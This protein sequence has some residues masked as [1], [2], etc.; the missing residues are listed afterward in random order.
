[1]DLPAITYTGRPT[2]SVFR[3]VDPPQTVVVDLGVLFPRQPFY[4]GRYNPDGLQM[5]ARAHGQLTCWG[6]CR[7]G[8]WW[9]LVTYPIEFGEKCRTVTHWIPAWILLKVSR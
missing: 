4:E 6:M 2:R 3:R 9:G 8:M 7:D 5:R 1:M